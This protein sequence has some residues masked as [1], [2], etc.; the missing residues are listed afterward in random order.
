MLYRMRAPTAPS[1]LRA[2]D[3]AL[4]SSEKKQQSN[5]FKRMAYSTSRSSV[6]AN[7]NLRVV[8]E[9]FLAAR[10]V[11]GTTSTRRGSNCTK[12]EGSAECREH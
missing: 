11:G 7:G 2:S 5:L 4:T 6:C 3:K 8:P 1:T 9:I 10:R 12:K